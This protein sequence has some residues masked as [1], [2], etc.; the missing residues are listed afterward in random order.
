MHLVLF[1]FKLVFEKF[2]VDDLEEQRWEFLLNLL[3]KTG[4]DICVW[5]LWINTAMPNKLSL[6]KFSLYKFS[7]FADFKSYFVCSNFV[8]L[9][10]ILIACFFGCVV[11]SDSFYGFVL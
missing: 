9:R 5:N 3:V 7:T 1:N 4:G 2:K 8:L 10:T 11:F 6:Y